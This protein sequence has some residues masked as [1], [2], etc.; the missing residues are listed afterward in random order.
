MRSLENRPASSFDQLLGGHATGVD[1]IQPSSVLNNTPIMR[2]R[3]INTITSGLFPLVIVDGVSV[4][5]GSIGGLI[6]NN[7]LSDINPNDIQNIDI[8][9]DA[10]A[11]ALYGS[12]AANGV[13]VITTKKGQK[14]RVKVNYSNWL[15]RSTPYN[16]PEL[17]NAEEY[18]MIKNEAMV[19]SGRAPGYQ[20]MKNADGST[21]NTSWY[22][23]AFRPGISHNHTL[24]VSGANNATKYFS[25]L[26]LL[27]KTAIFVTIILNATLQGSIS[28][29][30]LIKPLLWEPMST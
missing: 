2:I 11:A 29:I 28:R 27:I 23:V 5:V 3:G 9:K 1:I 30:K 19:N 8:L 25:P 18:T 7:P 21:V 22:D 20:L 4:F 14:G 24:S 15:S 12:R 26:D 17:L 16:L 6:G 10:S 13:M